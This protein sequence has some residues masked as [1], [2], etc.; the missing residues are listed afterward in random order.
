M[1]LHDGD[2]IM[3]IIDGILFICLSKRVHSLI[4]K[5][6]SL[7]MIIKLMG[8]RVWFNSTHSE[9]RNQQFNLWTW[10][11]TTIKLNDE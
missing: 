6:M 1:E 3:T 9:N 2:V 7:T 10:K 5:T 4:E 11:M 8:R